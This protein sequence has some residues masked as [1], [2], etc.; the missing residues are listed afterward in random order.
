MDVN[1]PHG[2]RCVCRDPYMVS[3]SGRNC[4][5]AHRETCFRDYIP[6]TSSRPSPQCQSPL[7]KITFPDCCCESNTTSKALGA[8]WGSGCFECPKKENENYPYLCDPNLPPGDINVCTLYPGICGEG[9]RCE[10]TKGGKHYCVCADGFE[11]DAHG[12]CHDID[13]CART[14]TVCQPGK[15]I[16]SKGSYQCQCPPSI[17]TLSEDGKRCETNRP[18]S[19][20]EDMCPNG[21]CVD[22]MGTFKCEC[23]P[24]FKPRDA[25]Y[26]ACDD[27]DECHDGKIRCRGRNE[28]CNNTAGNYECICRRGYTRTGP[29]GQCEDLDECKDFC[30]KG[31]CTNLVGTLR[32]EC[33]EGLVYDD[34]VLDCVGKSK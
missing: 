32:C 6:A 25:N 21:V 2:Y 15:C 17:S 9:A 22:M 34:D 3:E 31:K 5:A 8:A 27:I 23:N 12:K 13:E 16:N 29:N 7:G 19:S 26:Q 28:V 18:C 24:G 14:P 20:K 30:K 33:P 1:S 4:T 10:P 11:Q